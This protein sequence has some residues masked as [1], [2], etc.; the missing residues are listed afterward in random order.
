MGKFS[1]SRGEWKKQKQAGLSAGEMNE[2]GAAEAA[3]ST[4]IFGS[5]EQNDLHGVK[6]LLKHDATLV[7]TED[8]EGRTPLLFSVMSGPDEISK[9]LVSKGADVNVRLKSGET[10]LMIVAARR[11]LD[12]ARVL[13]SK[14][15]DVNAIEKGQGASVLHKAAEGGEAGIV[16]L[17]LSKG[18]DINRKRKDGW[19][20]L[21]IA[22]HEGHFD[23]VKTLVEKGAKVSMKTKDGATPLDAAEKS[24]GSDR[25]KVVD[26]LKST[27]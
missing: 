1:T 4:D 11:N 8:G 16:K 5:I 12:L 24:S 27:E 2:D 25:K 13:V 14:D 15:A 6:T 3:E 17:L 19:T 9:F 18:A 21:H 22:A 10:P 7:S 23:A 26:L 20:P